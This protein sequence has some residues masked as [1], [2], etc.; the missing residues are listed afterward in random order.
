ML[1]LDISAHTSE[2]LRLTRQWRFRESLCLTLPF[3]SARGVQTITWNPSHSKCLPWNILECKDI[4]KEGNNKNFFYHLDVDIPL[5]PLL[6]VGV[7]SGE[8][9]Q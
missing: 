1:E 6:K 8:I 7:W 2:S 5:S 9:V 4:D 3:Q